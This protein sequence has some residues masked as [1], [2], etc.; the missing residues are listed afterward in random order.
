[1]IFFNMIVYK[2]KNQ[3]KSP[4]DVIELKNIINVKI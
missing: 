1:M 3:N 4:F 2:N